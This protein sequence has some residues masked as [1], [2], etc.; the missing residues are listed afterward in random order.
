MS[1]TF[2]IAVL[3]GDGVGPEVM[4]EALRV[5]DAVEAKFHVDLS[6]Y[7]RQCGGVRYR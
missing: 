1:Q 5:L 6:T 4:A 7:S 2:K 3:A